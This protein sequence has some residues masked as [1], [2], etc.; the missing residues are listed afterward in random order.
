MELLDD[1]WDLP[2]SKN[3]NRD[4][5]ADYTDETTFDV[6]SF[7]LENNFHYVPLD[8][9]TRDL[10]GLTKEMDQALLDASSRSYSNFAKLCKQFSDTAET[11]PEL[12]IVKLDLAQ[13]LT[14]LS[15]LTESDISNTKEIV[16]D[17]VDYLKTLDKLSV[18]LQDSLTLHAGLQLAHKLCQAL[19]KLCADDQFFEPTLCGDLALQMHEVTAENRTK[20]LQLQDTESP[21]ILQL[22]SESHNV[23][24]R[25]QACLHVLCDKCLANPGETHTLGLK[26]ATIIPK[27]L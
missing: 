25:F 21:L 22:R 14:Q 3:I 23:T 8:I 7:L 12:Q 20:L 27:S 9:L 26:I 16:G 17:T 19:E 2:V 15:N 5:F 1:S 6:D 10:T 18:A 24:S 13:F 4:L 11:R